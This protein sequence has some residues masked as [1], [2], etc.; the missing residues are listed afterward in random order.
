MKTEKGVILV[1]YKESH[2]SRR[3]LVLKR[4]KNWE[5]WELP[6]G[7]LE[8]GYEGTV[9]LELAEEAG[10]DE[11]QI[12]DIQDMEREVSW[13]FEEA[14]EEIQ[15]EYRAYLV[16]VDSDAIVDVSQNP[17]DEHESGYFFNYDDVYSLLTYDDHRELLEEARETLE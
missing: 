17:H 15:R 1:V 10:I 9:R 6:K 7:H 16:E 4:T 12:V 3:F 11:E 8:D 13:T 5:G 2:G 14:G